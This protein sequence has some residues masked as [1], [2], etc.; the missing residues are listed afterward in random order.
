MGLLGSFIG[1]C[2]QEKNAFVKD[3]SFKCLS[4]Y[5]LLD[6]RTCSDYMKIYKNIIDENSEEGES[7]PSLLTAIKACFDFFLIFKFGVEE[8]ANFENDED[9][10]FE[11]QDIIES[12]TALMFK[13]DISAKKI[14]V[15]GFCKLL[16]NN[17][18]KNPVQLLALLMLIW[19]NPQQTLNEG[20]KIVQTLSMFY[21]AYTPY[22]YTCL[23]NT[24]QAIEIF[25]ELLHN[26]S[27]SREFDF[28]A[29]L[30]S[31]DLNEDYFTMIVRTALSLMKKEEYKF[32]AGDEDQDRIS[33]PE[34][35]FIFLALLASDKDKA[36]K[37]Y[38]KV[39]AKNLSLFEFEFLP[40]FN[41]RLLARFLNELAEEKDGAPFKEFL[42]KLQG[43]EEDGEEKDVQIDEDELIEA[44]RQIVEDIKKGK[45]EAKQLTKNLITY[46]VLVKS[47]KKKYQKDK[48]A[49]ELAN[50]DDKGEKEDKP[51]SRGRPP[52]SK[53]AATK[54]KED[55]IEEEKEKESVGEESENDEEEGEDEKTKKKKAG[56]ETKKQ[57]TK[58]TRG[59]R[60][61]AKKT[62]EE[63]EES[64]EESEEE[65]E[66]EKEEPQQKKG[67]G[68]PKKAA[69]E[70]SEDD[71][72]EEGSDEESSDKEEES[73]EE[74]QPTRRSPR[75]KI[76]KSREESSGKKGKAAPKGKKANTR[77]RKG[78]S[79][80]ESDES[81]SDQ[82]VKKTGKR[83]RTVAAANTKK[84]K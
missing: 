55:Q 23:K 39:L 43:K 72:E 54:K 20:T 19:I 2:F 49:M 17:K 84:K 27:E 41:R 28:N 36:S 67:R 25:I 12:L 3:L 51:K 83:T 9:G 53:T 30:F 33:P 48:A 21:K 75:G 10:T 69:K 62:K 68:R 70:E 59:K 60:G 80:A 57:Q 5:L 35:L 82:E 22:S 76:A 31:L 58:A 61:A 56:N 74:V 13:G 16:F 71:E 44:D 40:T 64:E 73:E 52:K 78:P 6:K 45:F 81:D 47:E 14:C 77:T 11:P 46:Q 4:L 1:P 79:K 24:E 42:K 50:H 8:D 66:S 34:R 29:D 38:K 37:P 26:V 7:V 63:K 15:E 65:E 32:G 18:V